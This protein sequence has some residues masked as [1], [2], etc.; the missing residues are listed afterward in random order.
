L[1]YPANSLSASPAARSIHRRV[2]AFRAIFG[3]RRSNQ[4]PVMHP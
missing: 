2:R 1:F 3:E 4:R